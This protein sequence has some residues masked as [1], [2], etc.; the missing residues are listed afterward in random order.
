MLGFFAN[1]YF[2]FNLDKSILKKNHSCYG[3]HSMAAAVFFFS[4][5]LMAVGIG[6]KTSSHSV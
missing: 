4:I 6:K 2:F 3:N 5:V 1:S